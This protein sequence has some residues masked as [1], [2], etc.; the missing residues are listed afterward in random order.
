MSK[1][2]VILGIS[3]IVGRIVTPLDRVK[4]SAGANVN[5]NVVDVKKLS[6]RRKEK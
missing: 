4:T 3:S 1:G 2:L 6:R 5:K